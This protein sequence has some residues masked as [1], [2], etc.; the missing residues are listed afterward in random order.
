MTFPSE[1][2]THERP[3]AQSPPLP[4]IRALR[5]EIRTRWKRPTVIPG[6][7]IANVLRGAL[8][9]TFRRLVCPEEWLNHECAPCPL[10]RDCAYGQVFAPTPGADAAKLRLQQ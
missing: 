1:T 3:P 8:G 6:S 9:M 4:Q 10:Y 2:L 5:L 7:V